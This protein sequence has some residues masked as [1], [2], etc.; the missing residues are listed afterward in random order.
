M[1]KLLI[2]IRSQYSKMSKTEKKI[3]DY[4]LSDSNGLKPLTITEFALATGASE[5]TIVRFAK[6]IGCAGYPEFKL[7]LAKE[8]KHIVNKSIEDTDDFMNMYSKISDDAYA[9]IT[10]TKVNLNNQLFEDSFN[11]INNSKKII[12]MGVG[13]SYVM[14]LDF[15]HKLL[16]LGYSVYI[17]LDSHFEV[18]SSCQSDENTVIIAITHS[19]YT[20]DIYEAITIAKKKG[21]KVITITSDIKS[22]IAKESNIVLCTDSDETN[23]RVLGLTSRYSQLVIFDTLYSYAVIHKEQAKENIEFIED[24]ITIKRLA[25]KK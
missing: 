7:L 24:S 2:E 18:I 15:Y 20:R 3:A 11:L 10:K 17:S 8:E 22:P 13:E 5:A 25:K 1:G 21:A 9:S 12:L 16:R 6:R 23:Y 14:S 19:G 4:L